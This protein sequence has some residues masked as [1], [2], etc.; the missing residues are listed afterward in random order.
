MGEFNYGNDRK[1]TIF[2][3]FKQMLR[4]GGFSKEFVDNFKLVLW[5]IPNGYYGKH[6]PKFEGLANQPNFFYMSGFD[7][8][9]LAFLMGKEVENEPVSIPRNSEELFE[10]AMKQ[11]LLLMLKI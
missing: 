6:V 10:E 1:S 4:T 9:G 5:D 3:Q 8:S 7:G 2:E 11:E